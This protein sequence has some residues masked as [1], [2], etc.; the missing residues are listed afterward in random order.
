MGP[1]LLLPVKILIQLAKLLSNIEKFLCA[2]KYF[3]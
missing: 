1:Y 2:V 3:G